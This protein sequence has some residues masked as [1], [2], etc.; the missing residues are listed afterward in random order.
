LILGN[1]KNRQSEEAGK[2]KENFLALALALG[3]ALALAIALAFARGLGILEL[4][5]VVAPLRPLGVAIRVV[6]DH[7]V[8]SISQ[9]LFHGTALGRCPCPTSTAEAPKLGLR[10]C[11]RPAWVS[12]ELGRRGGTV[13]SPRLRRCCNGSEFMGLST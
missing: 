7:T 11:G 10:G 12:D 13:V 4:T 3:L 1:I 2:D 9:R 6:N 5:L 8:L